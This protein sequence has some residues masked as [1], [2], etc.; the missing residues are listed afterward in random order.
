ME[1]KCK[2]VQASE[3][4][5]KY[6]TGA[7]I[8]ETKT[9]APYFYNNLLRSISAYCTVS[10]N[11]LEISNALKP[12]FLTTKIQRLL[13][14]LANVVRKKTILELKQQLKLTD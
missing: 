5:L 2:I 6:D 7:A 13:G 1:I 11:G 14:W 10:A 3:A 9:D 4:V 12:K 8:D